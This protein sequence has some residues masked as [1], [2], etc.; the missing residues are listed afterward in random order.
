MPRRYIP[1]RG[2]LV[3]CDFDP[4]C[5]HEQARQRPALVLSPKLFNQ[6]VG[7]A[8]VVPVTSTVRGHSFEVA[9]SGRKVSG[10]ALIQ[11]QRTI[12]YQARSVAFVE[13]ASPAVVSEALSK[14]RAI[15]ADEA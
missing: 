14:A 3:W 5:G 13:R 9:V 4:T 6:K 12:D 15:L 11:Q 7:L 10:M 1:E 8:L 2:D